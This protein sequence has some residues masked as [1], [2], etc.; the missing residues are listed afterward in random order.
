[1][2]GAP[3]PQELIRRK[4][5]GER[6]DAHAIQALVSGVAHGDWSD[7]HIAAFAMAVCLKGMSTDECSSLTVAMAASGRRLDWA[8][9]SL[10]GPVLDKHSTGGVGDKVSLVLAPMLAACGAHV[11][12]ISG[13]G[14]GHTGGTLDKLEAIPGYDV[15]PEATTLQDVVA[16]VGCAIVGASEDLAPADRRMYA[17]RDVTATVESVALITASILSKKMAEGLDALVM[18][19][20]TG[21]GAFAPTLDEARSLARSIVDVANAAGL[22]TRAQISDMGSVL[23]RQAGNALEIRESLSFLAGETPDPR[24]RE[25]VLAIGAE[26]MV[27]GGLSADHAGAIHALERT[28]AEGSALERFGRMAHA[29]GGPADL[30]ERPRAHLPEA[31]CVVPVFPARPGYVTRID[32]RRLG[33]A[34]V[35]LGGGR[36]HPSDRIDPAVGLS[37]VSALGEPVGAQRPLAIV[38]ARGSGPAGEAGQR[39]REAFVVGDAPVP[40]EPVLVEPVRCE[41]AA[42]TSS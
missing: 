33:L 6:L 20:K 34:I 1:M 15:R 31:P 24:L 10:D 4:R 7:A 30:I 2:A 17:V 12:M 26:L 5:D 29:L 14:L 27:L 8:A 36:I 38:H 3:L 35:G 16:R 18:D 42:P 13:R 32:V 25:V 28:L 21:S 41:E 19:V 22:P 39:V 9:H 23:G 11:P 37:Q 40:A